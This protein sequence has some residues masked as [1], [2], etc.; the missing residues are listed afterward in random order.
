M[1][2]K[3]AYIHD[4]A[5]LRLNNKEIFKLTDEQLMKEYL[6]IVFN[7]KSA[8]ERFRKEHHKAYGGI[9]VV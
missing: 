6:D 4:L 9:K 1:I 8:D 2:D 7:L 3:S 5:M